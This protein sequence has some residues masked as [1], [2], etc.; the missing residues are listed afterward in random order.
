ML[1]IRKWCDEFGL[2]VKGVH[3]TSGEKN[4]DLK[5]YVS[6]NEYNRLAG[7]ELVKNRVDLA[8]IL[9]AEAIVLHLLMP[10]QEIEKEEGFLEKHLLNVYKTFDEL[11]PYC[12]TRH[13][14][15]CIENCGGAP[16]LV[17][18]V[19]D[20]LYKRYDSGFLGL[21]FDT[22]HACQ[23]CKEN[24]LVYA[25]RYNDRIFMIHI[26]DNHG[27]ADEHLIPFEGYVDWEGFARVLARSPYSMPILMEPLNEA[28]E[29][30]SVWLKKAFEAGNRFTAMVGKYR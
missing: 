20:A 21:C 27:E 7:I 16:A 26:H 23:S 19:F 12:K 15:L 17:C 24:L 6:A 1:Q 22:G 25:E 18:A 2:G 28:G 3:A 29:E 4:S 10:W 9:N 13:I 30:D 8:H 14:R 11:E 5:D